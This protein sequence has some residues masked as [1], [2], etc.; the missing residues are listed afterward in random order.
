MEKRAA[1]KIQSAFRG[2]LA[3]RALRA[4]KGL[5]KIQALVRGNIVRKQAAETLRC[6]KALVRAQTRARAFR[7]FHSDT[8]PSN[9]SRS[10]PVSCT[11]LFPVSSLR[12]HSDRSP[13][14]LAAGPDSLSKGSTTPTQL[15]TPSTSPFDRRHHKNSLQRFSAAD[16]GESPRFCSPSSLSGSSR[17]GPFTPAKSKYSPNSISG[18]LNHPSYM[19]KTESSAAK[20]RSQSAPRQRPEC[21]KTGSMRRLPVH[22]LGDR[23][24]RSSTPK[25]KAYPGSGRLDRLGMPMGM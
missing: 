16:S 6:M 24:L 2:Y 21:G 13:G 22:E 1:V 17:R 11:P 19:A 10:Y 23:A 15:S 3:R 9:S 18:S 20:S 8:A 25:G 14:S 12:L 5:V 4:L 7:A